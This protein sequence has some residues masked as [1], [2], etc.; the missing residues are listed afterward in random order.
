MALQVG[1]RD[2]I[3]YDPVY[4]YHSKTYTLLFFGKLLTE[5]V[6]LRADNDMALHSH[7]PSRSI[8]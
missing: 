7:R 6:C 2:T 1:D 4:V 8:L 5:G 3:T